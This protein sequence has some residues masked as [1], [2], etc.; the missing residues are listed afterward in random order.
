MRTNAMSASLSAAAFTLSLTLA[1]PA[2]THS[3]VATDRQ[4]H[5]SGGYPVQTADARGLQTAESG[6]GV[7]FD[8]NHTQT[9]ETKRLRK[10]RTKR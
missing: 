1:A 4:A 6:S 5:R 3:G 10:R 8:I 7:F 2:Q 9:V